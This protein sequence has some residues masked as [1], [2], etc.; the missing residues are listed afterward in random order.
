MR[1]CSVGPPPL[2]DD[3][4]KDRS[5]GEYDEE[6]GS[7]PQ[8]HRPPT[9]TG[10]SRRKPSRRHPPMVSRSRGGA[11]TGGCAAA[12]YESWYGVPWLVETTVMDHRRFHHQGACDGEAPAE[13]P[14][15]RNSTGASPSHALGCSV[16]IWSTDELKKIHEKPEGSSELFE[17]EGPVKVAEK[18][19]LCSKCG[20]GSSREEEVKR[21]ILR[22]IG[23]YRPA[24]H[25][26]LHFSACVAI[27]S[28]GTH[29]LEVLKSHSLIA[30]H[31]T[32]GKPAIPHNIASVYTGFLI[33]TAS[34]VQR[35]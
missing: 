3:T 7:N 28:P 1:I 4:Y 9:L 33:A 6:S 13:F 5:G 15:P 12:T 18:S 31:K 24:V 34:E 10:K 14:R 35:E 22:R 27:S 2:D 23:Q 30:A 20:H 26:R 11:L 32:R 21:Q 8:P 29:N 16:V 17:V 25:L 19:W